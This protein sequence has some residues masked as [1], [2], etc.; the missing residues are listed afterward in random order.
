[1]TPLYSYDSVT[2]TILRLSFH[3]RKEFYKHAKDASLTHGTLNLIMF[4]GWLDHSHKKHI[5]R[6]HGLNRN[7]YVMLKFTK[8]PKT[9]GMTSKKTLKEISCLKVISC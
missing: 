5:V 4:E 1:M 2:K 7:L 9:P 8:R 6:K 3:L